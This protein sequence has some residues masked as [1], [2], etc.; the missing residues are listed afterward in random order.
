MGLRN[1]P[2][3]L[4][5]VL[6]VDGP[7]IDLNHVPLVINQEGR[8]QSEVTM[9]VKHVTVENVV[10]TG[11]VV[12]SL[13]DLER[14]APLAYQRF[15]VLGV[16]RTVNVHSEQLKTLSPPPRMDPIEHF[17]VFQAIH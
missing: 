5:D 11:E 7:P 13:E 3:V 1:A 8:W 10:N 6:R 14:K 15:Q 12:R 17:Q 16:G 4:F 9:P 2:K